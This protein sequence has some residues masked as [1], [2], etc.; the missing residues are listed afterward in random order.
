MSSKKSLYAPKRTVKNVTDCHFYHCLDFKSG[1]SV[2]GAWDLRKDVHGYLGNVDFA[3]KRILDVGTASGCLTWEMERLGGACVG[4]DLEVEAE[5]D[6]VPSFEPEK[7]K[8]G[9]EGRREAVRRLHNSWWYAHRANK[10]KAKVWYGTVYT[11]PEELGAFD[12]GVYGAI[13]VH[14]R[15]PFKA[16]QV[17]TRLVK[18]TVI[19]T[20]ELGAG[21]QEIGDPN[22][23]FVP[24]PGKV[25][26]AWWQMSPA[27]VIRMLNVLGFG[28]T[29]VTYHNAL[30]HGKPRRLFTVVGK[31]TDG[32][33]AVIARTSKAKKT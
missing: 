9:T 3:D 7:D 16:L 26:Y 23:R 25:G 24:K 1:E 12:I 30:C 28:K 15:D 2:T 20:E 4:V 18:D 19:V 6:V 33:P 11:I 21:P 13:L 29:T 10:S 5:W 27:A 31:R 8:L 32:L 22:V 17:G 14:L